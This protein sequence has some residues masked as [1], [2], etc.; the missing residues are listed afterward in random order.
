MRGDQTDGSP[1]II[2]GGF[3]PRPRVRGD[4]IPITYVTPQEWKKR[5]RLPAD[6]EAARQ[7]AI[8]TWPDKAEEYFRL[9]K[10]HGIAEACLIGLFAT[11][12]PVYAAR[13]EMGAA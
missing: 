3:D 10:A 12:I 5:F 4:G 1:R 8:E 6:K 2:G 11:Q 9:K 13:L 7:R